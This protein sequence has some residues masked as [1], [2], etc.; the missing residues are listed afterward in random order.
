MVASLISRE[1]STKGGHK[2]CDHKATNASGM[3]VMKHQNAP[4]EAVERLKN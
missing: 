3:L 2:E 4:Q 1:V